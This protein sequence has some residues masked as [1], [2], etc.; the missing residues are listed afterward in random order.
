MKNEEYSSSFNLEEKQAC[1]LAQEAV[2]RESENGG[3][4]FAAWKRASLK[5][6]V[7]VRTVHGEPSYWLFPVE[8]NG[9]IVGFVRVLGN[10][11]VA[12]VGSF[13]LSSDRRRLP[14]VTGLTQD[15]AALKARERVH[16]NEGEV[17]S[18]PLYVHDG[19]I[20][21]E[22]WLIE[23][24]KEGKPQ[25]WIFVTSGFIYER[26]AGVELNDTFE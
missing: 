10:G 25:R 23:V 15:E 18:R 4:V 20:G 24:L 16:S 5:N 1:E 8:I 17:L 7:M 19:P 21:R 26:P 6:P 3:L 22:A 13:S 2:D 9:E 14:V 11:R 12:H